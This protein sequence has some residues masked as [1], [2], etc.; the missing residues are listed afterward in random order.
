MDIREWKITIPLDNIKQITLK[1]AIPA[2]G[3]CENLG[4]YRFTIDLAGGHRMVITGEFKSQIPDYWY[5]EHKV[6]V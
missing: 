2:F 1:S 3:D 6:S 5:Y 4:D